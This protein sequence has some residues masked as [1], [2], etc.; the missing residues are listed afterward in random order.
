M[1]HLRLLLSGLALLS[2]VAVGRGQTGA[3]ATDPALA[4]AQRVVQQKPSVARWVG[5]AEQRRAAGQLQDGLADLA[6]A[7]AAAGREDH[8][9]ELRELL[10]WRMLPL[11]E[12]RRAAFRREV[13]RLN[14]SAWRPV[15]ELYL[16]VIER[17]RRALL[18]AVQRLPER[19]PERFP[20][21]A[22][23]SAHLALLQ[24]L[25]QRRSHAA[26]EVLAARSYEPLHA[27]RDLDRSL[28][29]EAEFLGSQGQAD[30]RARVLAAR[31][32][33]RA[34]YLRSA[35]N[36][37]ERLFALRL[38]DRL[39]E[40]DALLARVKEVPYLTDRRR[41]AELFD[42]LDEERAWTVLLQPLLAG[43]VAVVSEPPDLARAQTSRVAELH[44][45]ART[46]SGSG[47]STVY[48]GEVRA[49]LGPLRLR[50][51]R[52]TVVRAGER[53]GV[54]L[55]GT[56][57][58]RVEGLPG[59]ESVRADRCTF[60]SDT[61]GCTFGG[62]VQL[63]QATGRLKLRACSVT[64]A[65]EVREQ[66]SLLDDFRAAPGIEA[67]VELLPRIARVYAD[68]ELPVEVRYFLA[69]D[70]LRPHLS[71]HA[72]YLPPVNKDVR[73]VEYKRSVVHMDDERWQEAMSGEPWMMRDVPQRT[74]E[75]F[76][77]A[78]L[79]RKADRER[80]RLLKKASEFFWRVSDPRHPDVARARRLLGGVRGELEQRARRW[81][82][83]IERNNTVLTFD[84][85][86]GGPAGKPF[87]VVLDGR[88]A[89]RVSLKLYRV[90][91]TRDLL[92]VLDRIGED[93]VY[94]DY[95][96]QH[97]GD[98]RV[99]V[100]EEL[101]AIRHSRTGVERTGKEPAPPDWGAEKL[102]RHWHEPIA[103]LKVL[104]S[105]RAERGWYDREHWREEEEDSWYFDD[106]P[107]RFRARLE[108]RYRSRAE[109]P[110][111]WQCDRVLE[112]PGD[113]LNK[114][115]AYVLIAES[116]G[117]TAYVPIVI[118]P[119]SLTLRRCRDGV[120]VLASDSEGIKPL[121]G[122]RV[123]SKELRGETVTDAQGVA[124]AR[125]F[126]SGERAVV[127]E[128]EGRVAVGGFGQVFDGIY[129]SPLDR[130]WWRWRNRGDRARR[131]ES[132][133][134]GEREAQLYA[135]RHILAAYTN[136][137]TYR[138]GQEVHFKLI[139][140]RLQPQPSPV[141][142][143]PSAFRAEEFDVPVNLALPDARKP[144]PYAVVD[145]HGRE[146]ASGRLT[147][148][149]FGT[150]AGKLTLNTEAALGAYSLRVQVAGRQRVLP[151]VFAVKEYRRPG[152]EVEIAGVPA[153]LTKPRDLSVDVS[154][155]Y[156]FGKPLAGGRVEARLVRADR[157][158]AVTTAEDRLDEKGALRLKLH[159]PE[160]LDPGAY[161]VV[162]TVGDDSGR[163]V[164][165]D[166]PLE[167]VAPTPAGGPALAG[168]PRFVPAGEEFT[169][170]TTAAEVVATK[171]KTILRFGAAKGVAKIRLAAPG[172]YRLSASG[173][174]VEV[175]AHGGDEHPFALR[176]KDA[177][178]D[179]AEPWRG[180]WVNL[181][182]YHMQEHGAPARC[183]SEE[184]QLL[185]LFDQQQVAVGEKLR[186]L[187]YIP[188]TSARLLLAIE[189]RTILD[190]VIRQTALGAGHYQVIEIPIKQRYVPGF[191]LQGRI[192]AGTGKVE[193]GR[194]PLRERLQ[195]LRRDEDEGVDPRWCRVD[196]V[197][198]DRKPGAEG[199]RVAVETDRADF[200]PGDR[201]KVRLKV[202]DPRGRP[203][204]AEVS[205]GA[206]DES[207]Y[208]FGEDALAALVPFFGTPQEEPRFLP[209]SWRSSLGNRP[210]RLG[211]GGAAKAA[212]QL[213]ELARQIA[214]VREGTAAARKLAGSIDPRRAIP[215]SML[216][217]E[218]PVGG[219]PLARLRQ[220]FRETASWQPQLRTSADGLAE[221]SFRLPDSLT[222]YRLS[223]LAVT[224]A[225]AVG[226][227][228]ARIRVALP[229]AVQLMLP[230]FAVEKDR[231]LAVVLLHNDTDRE[232]VC[233][234]RWQCEGAS[235]DGATA[236]L[237]G[238]VVRK[239]K[240]RITGTGR[241][242][243]PAHGSVRVGVWLKLNRVGTVTVACHATSADLADAE[244]RTLTVQP[245]GRPHEVA[246][247]GAL[248][249]G[250][251]KPQEKRL[252]LPAG[253]LARE[254][255]ITVASSPEA[256]ALEGLGYLVDY[257]YGCI[258]QTMSRF[259]PAVMVAHAARTARVE[260]P[261]DV[262][263]R[264]P[265][266]LS[267]GLARVYNFQQADGAWGWFDQDDRNDPM[268]VY[269][270][271]GLARCRATS[272]TVDQGV[273][274]RGCAYLRQQLDGRRLAPDLAARAW[275]ALALAEQA[276]PRQLQA[277][278][279]RG[280]AAH[281]REARCNL[282]LACRTVGLSELG[283]RLWA[284]VRG[285]QPSGTDQFALMLTTQLAYGASWEDCRRTSQ[286]LLALRQGERWAHTRDTSWALEA[287]SLMLGYAPE[288]NAARRV[289]IEVGGRMVL[290]VSDPL[291]LRKHVQRIYL[292]AGRLPAREG[293]DIRVSGD[294]PEP[295]HFTLRAAGV[296]RL[297]EL[298]PT[299]TRV[300]VVRR[301]ETLDGKPLTGAGQVGTVL[302][303]RLQ[304]ELEQAENY[305]I[306]EERRPAGCEFAD[307]RIE[308]KVA[309]QAAN[310]DW[311]DDRLC[312]FFTTLAPG[313]HEVV[314]YLR[315]ETPGVSH[316]LPG[317]L[318]PMYHERI[319]GETGA[320][321]IEVREAMPAGATRSAAQK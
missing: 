232:R 242:T 68:D 189:G 284:G 9:G 132:K 120:F 31:E 127:V 291:T 153:Q 310:V 135:D 175:F 105:G 196:V 268:T 130:A 89:D 155:R 187:V 317:C 267:K 304:M 22:G 85:P 106:N 184:Q 146:V 48:Q 188:H 182:D 67:K 302:R 214:E 100:L 194:W 90:E 266:V 81:L 193:A 163:T 42:R 4:R 117:Q 272:T 301:L 144:L 280:W 92:W 82:R 213:R 93:F 11:T 217:G 33:L 299:G 286:A 253:F 118:D 24:E 62:D 197:D 63:V 57:A 220:D 207:V 305:L 236:T 180:D 39:A 259:L 111:S 294:S 147:P 216:G 290:D 312:V 246:L 318:Y 20:T 264:L 55:A 102:V 14:E 6:R 200:R 70:L 215:P 165:A 136:R 210:R 83:E 295:M 241:V 75:A 23:E 32:R 49:A 13:A 171:E 51:E 1:P 262:A 79:G 139:M 72:P 289:S 96:L 133:A 225:G 128:H 265:D 108:K 219:V 69:L 319:R 162:C 169:V 119:L 129:I 181:S 307:E 101:R 221:M 58:V 103:D 44:V 260:L 278:I 40:R 17:D 26:L 282:A 95:D 43:E 201:V 308:G 123:L 7:V 240:D 112:V 303:V 12:P 222:R 270:V 94:R 19:L 60:S 167:I 29:R 160:Q 315:A 185:A 186:L 88:N 269:V 61:G 8:A 250:P 293:L 74:R 52:L 66:T 86:G 234:V 287:L 178:R 279:Q 204:R 228:R 140:R 54:V 149:E 56:G 125:L 202:T 143:K 114:A 211:E 80:E 59:I 38:L 126:A 37:V 249:G 150:A 238:W 131:G 226:V 248:E 47:D 239:E 191:Y 151:Q 314:Y 245:L 320:A 174:E 309:R 231:L 25:G 176:K 122:A 203:Q 256:Q 300:R 77:Q 98:E 237:A 76:Q 50:C 297:D 121:V 27:L 276:D 224:K 157:W 170:R 190:Y 152:F 124:F 261:P 138:P 244:S 34:A 255:W 274:A 53:A 296:Q 104:S 161:R 154:G 137:P 116:N 258:E 271:Y 257:P 134:S 321:R 141:G 65:G 3:P 288:R 159:M 36:V 273:L 212:Q 35:R 173:Q 205:F 218:L 16:A 243:V 91:R 21:A 235:F 311:R 46:R 275:Y 199:L 71:W 254:L 223:A 107:D 206:V 109:Q 113:A 247:N 298:E 168:V 283:E 115:G 5:L 192:L 64:R 252:I 292:P 285:W 41:L 164:S 233:D 97:V 45:Q 10:C 30:H 2:I 251:G 179:W 227:G 313:R 177:K 148:S 110:S 99:K 78:L 156:Y 158:R 172:W 15:Y 281:S 18:A 195:R 145:P 209:G 28:T 142:A 306:L 73:Q 316:I 263:A 208:T 277:W 84:I 166:V 230:R 198:P 87:P 229:L 183:E